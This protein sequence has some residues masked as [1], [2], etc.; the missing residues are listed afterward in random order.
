MTWLR[1]DDGF[2]SNPKVMALSEVK[3]WRWVTLLLTCARHSRHGGAV[4]PAML[5]AH[6]LQAGELIELG[7]LDEDAEGDVF[8]WRV[9]DWTEFN[10]RLTSDAERQQRYRNRHREGTS[11]A[12]LRRKDAESDVTRLPEV[13]EAPRARSRPV[14]NPSWDRGPETTQLLALL[15]V[16]ETQAD[17]VRG[18]ALAVPAEELADVLARVDS[19]LVRDPFPY[20]VGRLKAAADG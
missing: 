14:R 5:K 7:L 11:P 6:G 12:Q 17:Y 16:D 19:G 1:L 18:L 8:P 3:R 20:V 9:H 2:A 10:R 15:D 4:S 13:T